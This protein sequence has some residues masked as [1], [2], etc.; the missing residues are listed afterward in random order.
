MLK[1]YMGYCGAPEEGAVLIFAESAKQAKVIGFPDVQGWTQCE[2]TDMRVRLIKEHPD[3]LMTLR[4]K[5]TPHCIDNVPSCP[6]CEFWGA[7]LNADRSACAFCED[8]KC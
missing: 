4:T 3:Y 8:E 1:P 6:R 5:D 7:P 2:F